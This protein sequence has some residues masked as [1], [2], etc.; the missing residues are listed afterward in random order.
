[1]NELK[2]ELKFI[3]S[4][5]T[6]YEKEKSLPKDFFRKLLDE[7]DWTFI[8]KIHTLIEAAVTESLAAV[9]NP[10]LLVVLQQLSLGDARTGKLKFAE[11]L[12]LLNENQLKFIKLLSK[13]RNKLAHDIKN[14]DFKFSD[15]IA[16]LDTNQSNN[17]SMVL[18]SLF[19]DECNFAN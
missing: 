17:F 4:L 5:L 13:I 9:I 3:F 6:K 1:M 7:D 15:Y 11:A 10:K 8:I 18:T 16:N 14:I 12:G 19:V 2:D